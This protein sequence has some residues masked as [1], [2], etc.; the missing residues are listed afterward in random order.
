[1]TKLLEFIPA[2]CFNKIINH[3]FI[4]ENVFQIHIVVR[5]LIAYL[6][7]LNVNV[8]NSFIMLRVFDESDNALIIFEDNNRLK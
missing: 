8:F 6:M 3:L 7:I 1:M 4:R 5:Y 2:K